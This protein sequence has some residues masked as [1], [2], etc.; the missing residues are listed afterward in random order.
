V[1]AIVIGFCREDAESKFINQEP[2][3]AAKLPHMHAPMNRPII[4]QIKEHPHAAQ[5]G[6]PRF[7][8]RFA[9]DGGVFV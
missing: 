5:A 2:S 6:N 4:C 8:R 9:F 3:L 1:F 7:V